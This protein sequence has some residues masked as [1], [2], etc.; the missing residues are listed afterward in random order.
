MRE[1]WEKASDDKILAFIDRVQARATTPAAPEVLAYPEGFMGISR[2][3]RNGLREFATIGVHPDGRWAV[4]EG[5]TASGDPMERT[6]EAMVVTAVT[7]F[8]AD[9]A[10]DA[11]RH[12]FE[13]GYQ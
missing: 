9:G 7:T 3:W 13:R 1:P 6:D 2:D 4:V 11:G 8:T 12:S 10:T 5:H